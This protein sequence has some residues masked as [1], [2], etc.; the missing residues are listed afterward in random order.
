MNVNNEYS[1]LK[2][3]SSQF[4]LLGNFFISEGKACK[5]IKIEAS[6]RTGDDNFISTIRKILKTKYGNQPVSLGGVFVITSGKA[7]LHIMP[8]F[9]KI[10]LET[11][12]DVNNWL[13]FFEMDSPLVC[14]TSFH[15][16]D[17]DL[18]LRMEHTHCFS[19]HNQGGH[20]H[21]DTTPRD[22]RFGRFLKIQNSI[23]N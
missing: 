5:V 19:D 8:D 10:P 1:L 6:K 11:D 4:G 9:S 13:K 12:D 18:D 21:Y 2:S 7:K 20:Y 15:S 14:L 22:V 17:P 16:H 23:W 3:N